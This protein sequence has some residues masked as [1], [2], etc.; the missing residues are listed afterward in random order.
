MM[1]RLGIALFAAMVAA[2]VLA[3]GALAQRYPTKAVTLIV[4]FPAG[5]RTDVAARVVTQ[6]MERHL[7]APTV[8]VNKAGAGGVLGAK[9]VGQARPD[10]YTLGFFSTGAVTAQYTVPTPLDLKDY[11]LIAIV[12][13][14]PA[15]IAVSE[16][17]PWKSIQDVVK[18]ARA[19]PGKFRIGAQMGA[20]AHVFAGA[21]AKAAGIQV[22]Y[23]PLKGDADGA[24]G[25]AGGHIEAHIGV[26]VSYK[27]LVEARKLRILGV[28][29]DTRLPLY[30][31]IP[32]WKEQG[33]DVVVASF[34]GVFA[35]RGT[36]EEVLKVLETALQKTM[37]E[38]DVKDKME[39]F[40]LG[41]VYLGRKEGATYL[42][43][44]DAIF[45]V[46]IRDLGMMVAPQK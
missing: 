20:S 7:G 42:A 8:V 46:L 36:P 43:K 15:A 28:A 18:Y 39:S 21:F 41:W 45:R 16:S 14:D 29:D 27:S 10:G 6:F 40:G 25:V 17:A 5:G 30:K 24:V 3:P 34:H 11:E 35:P 38:K 33:V 37:L 19:N 2:G 44:Q 22:T 31:D 23:V 13:S 1:G 26:P 12:N 32:T 9:E 4:P